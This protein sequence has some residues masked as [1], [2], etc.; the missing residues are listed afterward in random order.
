MEAS[1]DLTILFIVIILPVIGP[2]VHAGLIFVTG[3]SS[4]SVTQF[5]L[6][7]KT[8]VNILQFQGVYSSYLL[9][10]LRAK[11]LISKLRS[12]WI[13]ICR[14]D[15][16]CSAFLSALSASTKGF[17]YCTVIVSRSSSSTK[18]YFRTHTACS[19]EIAFSV[20]DGLGGC[21]TTTRPVEKCPIMN[22][23]R[24]SERPNPTRDAITQSPSLN[25]HDSIRAP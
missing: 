9:R 11:S 22:L 6:P 16:S 7:A 3:L 2:T 17:H 15:F 8:L 24:H 25:I 4:G 20:S 21:R 1:L 10:N 13:C 12:I 14:S 5:S 23:I 19:K 18:L